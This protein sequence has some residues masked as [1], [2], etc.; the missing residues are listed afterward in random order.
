MRPRD[1]REKHDLLLAGGAEVSAASADDDAFDG[2]LAGSAWFSG[3]RVDAVVELEE[4]SDTF[5][6]DVVGD[7]GAA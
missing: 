1:S 7:G 2:G 3:A 4:A 5:G 6:V